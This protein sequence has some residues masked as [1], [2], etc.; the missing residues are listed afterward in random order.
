M[1]QVEIKPNYK[2]LGNKH[3]LDQ[4]TIKKYSERYEGKASNRNKPSSCYNV[5]P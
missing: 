4:R 5:V 2:A 1:K 3:G